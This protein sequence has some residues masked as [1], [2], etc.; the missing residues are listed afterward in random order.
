MTTPLDV[1]SAPVGQLLAEHL[2]SSCSAIGELGG[3]LPRIEELGALI[4]G[5]LRD[6]GRLLAA[7]NGGSAAHAQHLTSELVGRFKD[8]RRP[9]SAI[10]LHADPS[11][12]TA[13]VNDYGADHMFA[14]QVEAHARPGDVLVLLSTSGRSPNVVRAA[15]AARRVG[16]H[17][18]A[19][20]GRFPNP[21]AERCE[22][23]IAVDAPTAASV[24]EAHQVVVHLL[25]VAI[26][27]HLEAV[28]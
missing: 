21:L 1:T 26:E 11:C 28:R 15:E 4:A 27:S 16:A 17:P 10:S 19:V 7:G 22:Q 8:E 3:Q 6:G 13:L 24:Q 9:Y 25:C 20:T 14:R 2:R 5:V 12:V 23:M 18:I